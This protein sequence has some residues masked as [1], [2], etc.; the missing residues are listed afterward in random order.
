MTYQALFLDIDGTIL[1]YDHSYTEL[2]KKAIQEAQSKGIEVFIATGRPLHEL[3]ELRAELGIRSA[4]GYN[5]AYAV[6]KN[7][8]ILDEPMDHDLVQHTLNLAKEYNNE[9]VLYTDQKNFFTSLTHPEVENFIAH[10]QLKENELY[11]ENLALPIYSMTVMNLSKEHV[12]F[13]KQLPNLYVSTVNVEGI[14]KAYDLIQKNI[15]KGTAV[16][17][18]LA[19]LGIPKEQ[20]IAFGDGMN[21]KEMLQTVGESF[22]M[23]NGDPNL[24]P[25]AKHRTTTVDNSGI[26]YGLKKLG[27]IK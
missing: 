14:S 21:D 26:Y 24:F 25:Y 4:I 2:T 22:V 5:G 12:P 11:P 16:E 13:Y 17:R 23:A 18:V 15:N 10:F 20:A 1:T 9:L 7:N 3:D 19:V 8:V 27:I 6:Y